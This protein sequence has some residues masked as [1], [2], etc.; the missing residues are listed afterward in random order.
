MAISKITDTLIRFANARERAYRAAN[1]L[2]VDKAHAISK[3]RRVADFFSG[4][5]AQVQLKA[6]TQ[7]ESE[8]T[9][10]LPHPKSRF[11][12]LREK[13]LHIIEQAHD[14]S[15]TAHQTA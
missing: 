7:V 3:I 1:S 15:R 14:T 8:L 5:N 11:R 2:S 12:K 4:K 10:I 13:I 9:L 6:V